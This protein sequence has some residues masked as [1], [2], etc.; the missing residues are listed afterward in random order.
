MVSS[1]T[2]KIISLAISL[3][4]VVISLTGVA[5]GAAAPTSVVNLSRYTPGFVGSPGKMVRDAAGN[6]YVTDFWGKG[7]VK[8]NNQGVKVGFIP[9][10][11]R[12]SAVAVLP[13]SRL[14]VA[15]AVPQPKIAFYSQLGAAPN[16]TGEEITTEPFEAPS[17]P[18]LYRPSGIA[19]DAAGYIYVV[20][21]G[22]LSTSTTVNVG[23]VRVYSAT[24]AF[25][26]SFGTRTNTNIISTTAGAFK[27]P[28][29]I[30]YEK[31]NNQIVVVDTM[32]HRLQF[33][34]A[35]NGTS[36]T[37]VV[38]V[39]G[40]FFD[41]PPVPGALVKFG[42]P[43]DV[44]FEYNGTALYRMY[45]TERSR[46]EIV[47]VNM[48]AA[49]I[50]YTRMRISNATTPSGA[51]ISNQAI[52]FPS[53]VV[54]EKTATG[55]VLYVANSTQ[56]DSSNP[57]GLANVLVLGIDNG[58][59]PVPANT[60]TMAAVPPNSSSS[61][62]TVTGTIPAGNAVTCKVNG[63]EGGTP[64]AV[65]NSWTVSG[66]PLVTGDNYILCQSTT[67]ENKEDYTYFGTPTAA[68]SLAVTEPSTAVTTYT[69]NTTVTVK[70]TTTPGSATVQVVNS[71]GGTTTTQSDASGNWSK[72]IALI[73]GVNELLVT[74]WKQ[75]TN[76]S[77]AS[78][79]T[80]VGDFTPPSMAGTISFI[81]AGSTTN[82]A[83][84]NLDGIVLDA[85]LQSITVNGI[86]V[87]AEAQVAMTGNNTYFSIPV[88]LVRDSNTVTVIAADKAGNSTTFSR[89]VALAPEKPGFSVSLPA[90]NKF[91]TT[92]SAESA[93]GTADP[94]YNSVVACGSSVV[95]AAGE[96]NATTPSIGA[97]F[98][99]CQFTASDGVSTVSEKRTF[100]TNGNY[101]LVAIT[102]PAT[103]IATNTS[104]IAIS[105]F[106]A[107]DAATPQIQVNS[108]AV[109]SVNGYTPSTGIFTANPVTLSPGINTVKIISNGTTALRNII[110]D[111]LAPALTVRADSKSM[112]SKIYGSLEPSAKISA[113]TAT[114]G[115]APVVIPLSKIAFDPYDQS[116]AVVW[117]ADLNGYTYDSISF[118]ALDPAGNST[119]LA[120]KQ[121][122]PTGDIDGD[123]SV[124][125]AD[126]LAALRH[127]AGTESIVDPDQLF[128]GD[129]GA[130]VNGRASRDGTVDIVDSVL[131]LNKAYGLLSF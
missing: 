112:P 51:N 76:S 130:L 58:T 113:I 119:N 66:L 62:I 18:L 50:Y 32:N 65:A 54:F 124:R 120:Y 107:I 39:G 67:G 98:V 104:N 30:V 63:V 131:I 45:V 27:Q 55:G 71:L 59:V 1:T 35:Y 82:N 64:S 127:V 15:V 2:R 69:S 77:T 100:N 109:S 17:N 73:E 53:G 33:F 118:T 42:D 47:V 56:S 95:P 16:I 81:G 12:P 60:M 78:T 28:M 122:I 14:V 48:E 70:G 111:N 8:L 126:A 25:L 46:D 121:G 43:T 88:T 34:T 94:A 101:N 108:G 99:S 68:P 92:V 86:P 52:K 29:G 129:V 87:S 31:Q 36:C 21:S 7:I 103:D 84:Q 97:G 91:K 38:S 13:S 115:G 22:D 37:H 75:G 11:G 79:V 85:N 3:L 9:T 125:L 102:T 90:D 10:N 74:A 83:V 5:F 128:N 24:G 114:L 6:F 123:G 93:S 116:G 26:Y 80:V 61:P 110:Y 19:I 4:V 41:T 49:Q 72:E 23:K 105:G 117:S 44:A 57:L 89:S 20:D 40:S 106:V 96:W